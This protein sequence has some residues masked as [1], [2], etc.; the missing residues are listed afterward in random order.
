MSKILDITFSL[1]EATTTWPGDTETKIESTRETS[2]AKSMV[3]R[4]TLSSHV[5]TH[6]DAPAHFI[7]GAKT[8]EALPLDVLIGECRV[9]EVDDI[10]ITAQV[11]D[12]LDIPK[13]CERL[14]FKTANSRRFFGTE[15]FVKD[16]V[17]ISACGARRLADLGVKLIGM[18]YLTVA[19]Y[20]DTTPVH[21]TLLQREI[22]LV[23]SL[24]LAE[25]APGKYELICLPLKLSGS[26]GAPCRAVLRQ[27][28][29]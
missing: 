17:G 20:T 13:G 9:V 19:S 24:N 27:D 5:G 28:S 12:G 14:L 7:E 10:E 4:L 26:D 1:S 21:Q 6:V 23:E 15:P 29:R 22:I 16:Y 3:S 2:G 18:D 8:V 25:V 11:V